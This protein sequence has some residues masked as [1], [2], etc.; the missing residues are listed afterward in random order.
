MITVVA[1]PRSKN[2]A[3]NPYQFLLYQAV[4]RING[5]NVC[6]FSVRKLFLTRG[7]K[8]LHVHWPDVFLAAGNRYSFWLRLFALRS[9]FSLARALGIPIVWTAHNIKRHGQRHGKKLNVLFWPWF[10]N[11]I[12]AVIYMN[13]LSK[14][15]AEKMFDR[16][17]DIPNGV[18]PHGHY[19]SIIGDISTDTLSA[20]KEKP[21]L[22]FFGAITKY[23][24]GHKLLRTFLK[25][26]HGTAH[27]SMKGELSKVSPDS[28]LLLELES[29]SESQRA[30]VS[31]ENRFLSDAELVSEIVESDIVVFPYSDVLNSGAAIFALSVGRPILCSDTPLFRELRSKIGEDWVLLFNGELNL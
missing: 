4:E 21:R 9:I 7:K 5:I 14:R 31:F 29:M 23:K 28:S 30:N 10:A 1:W 18:I 6:E 20:T 17:S 12:D 22:L 3:K 15:N 16:W 19:R 25:L 24:N 27:L 11:N 13:E 2:K 8:I 26:P